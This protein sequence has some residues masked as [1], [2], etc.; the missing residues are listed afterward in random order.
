MK[1]E[2]FSELPDWATAAFAKIKQSLLDAKALAAPKFTTLH[3]NPFIVGLDFSAKS[4]GVALSQVQ[5]GKDQ[6]E[7]WR[8]LYCFARKNTAAGQNYS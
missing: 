3:R 7:H 6:Q 1:T 8:L 2:T 4:I 5:Q